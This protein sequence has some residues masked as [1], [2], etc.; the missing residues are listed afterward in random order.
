MTDQ[1]FNNH[2]AHG[3]LGGIITVLLVNINAEDIIKT[4][5]L[6][7]VGAVVSVSV[8]M[9]CKYWLDKRRK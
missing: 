6:A 9:A 8:S 4:A 1:P 5:V 7:L 2:A 3:T